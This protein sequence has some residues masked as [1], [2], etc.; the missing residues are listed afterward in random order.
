MPCVKI[1]K[2]SALQL[3]HISLHSHMIS[4]LKLFV[5]F[6]FLPLSCVFPKPHEMTKRSQYDLLLGLNISKNLHSLMLCYGMVLLGICLMIRSRF[7]DISPS[8]QVEV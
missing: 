5:C 8:A 7:C 1:F 2:D 4:L 6:Y 3:P